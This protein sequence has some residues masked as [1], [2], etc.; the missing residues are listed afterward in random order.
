[1]KTDVGNL[2]IVPQPKKNAWQIGDENAVVGMLVDLQTTLDITKLLEMFS[3][4]LREMVPHASYGFRNELLDI[5]LVHGKDAHHV[6]TYTL[7]LEDETLGE[8]WMRRDRR[9]SRA[10]LEQTEE[11]LS[12][13]L[14]PLRNCLRY[15]E[16]ICYAHTDPLTQVGNRVALMAEL[17]KEFDLARRYDSALV[18][19]FLDIDHFKS[20]NDNHGHEAGDTVLRSVAQTI[21]EVVRST[22]GVF[23]YGGEEFVI[24]FN[25]VGK[26]GAA[27]L[28]ERIRQAVAARGHQAGG[29]T[30]EVTVSLGVALLNQGESAMALMHRADQ[31]MYT[32]KRT[33]RNR[34][35]MAP[36]T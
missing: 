31:A 10:D 30:L 5:D 1:M 35:V 19:I 11:L 16:A 32:A 12:H 6:C 4:H 21:K 27:H 25:N 34:V 20:I 14:Y 8:W 33:G 17:Q 26:S 23:R 3:G 15:R 36:E 28:A 22:D 7:K 18:V 24:M 2:A 29:E 13:L 9:F